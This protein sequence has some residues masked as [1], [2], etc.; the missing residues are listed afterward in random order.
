MKDIRKALR[1]ILLANTSVTDVVSGRIYPEPLPQGIT[2]RSIVYRTI[3]EDTDYH[4]NGPSGLVHD[5]IQFDAIGQT[6]DHSVE[7]ANLIK[8]ELSGFHGTVAYGTNSPQE[9][10]FIH[11]VFHDNGRPIYD[12]IAK[13]YLMQ[14]D[15]IVWYYD[16]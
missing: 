16:R 2:A 13:L 3:D 5:R 10:V 6:A 12:S 15:Y 14:R 11:A 8:D 4:M 9:S 1:A 7:L